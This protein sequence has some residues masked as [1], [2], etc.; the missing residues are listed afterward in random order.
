MHERPQLA[1]GQV[2]PDHR[3][4]SL[5]P[6]PAEPD[7]G[8]LLELWTQACCEPITVWMPMAPN[9]PL[10]AKQFAALE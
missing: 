10:R 5:V 3:L 8:E 6:I 9:H 4:L 7:G 1:D 2:R